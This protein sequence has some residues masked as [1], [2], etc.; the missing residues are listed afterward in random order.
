MTAIENMHYM[1]WKS[2]DC[3]LTWSKKLD[4]LYFPDALGT[5]FF[6]SLN[7]I[8]LCSVFK[9]LKTSNGFNT[10]SVNSWPG[11][12][13]VFGVTDGDSSVIILSGPIDGEGISISHDRGTSWVPGFLITGIGGPINDV[14]FKNTDTVYAVTRYSDLTYDSTFSMSYNRGLTW[15]NKIFNPNYPIV[16]PPK[17]RLLK[18]C[19]K[20]T[21]EIYVLAQ[22][23]QTNAAIIFKTID[24][25]ETWQR[26]ITPFSTP[27]NDMVFINDSVAL[28]SGNSGLLFKWNKIQATYTSIT[29]TEYSPKNFT[30]Y[31][32]P[33]HNELKISF[34]RDE[35]KT[36]SMQYYLY[37][38]VG[39]L[40]KAGEIN[41]CCE[42]VVDVKSVNAGVYILR[43]V[44][45]KQVYSIKVLKN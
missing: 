42:D 23:Y 4:T 5:V 32:N 30:I 7:G 6:D 39:M 20:S 27:L 43:V 45:S 2:G 26:Y 13:P 38:Y 15:K 19:I 41:N 17:H 37:N 22:D 33:T 24:Q 16:N 1:I 29:E 44:T 36:E 25:G 12:D 9:T 28:V 40:I 18:L 31:P 21:Q 10:F 8:A 35:M 3:G 14:K 11:K 34:D